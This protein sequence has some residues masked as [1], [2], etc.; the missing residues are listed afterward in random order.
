MQVRDYEPLIEPASD[1]RNGEETAALAC[2]R[3]IAAIISTSFGFAWLGWGST[4]LHGLP[5]EIWTAYLLATCAL[6]ALA[7]RALRRGRKMLEAQEGA[8]LR[9]WQRRRKAYRILTLGEIGGCLIVVALANLFHRTDWIAVG[10][11]FVVGLHFLPLSRILGV[12]TY[13]WVGASI[14]TFDAVAIV[15]R[16][17]LNPTAFA[18]I[19]TGLILWISAIYALVRSSGAGAHAPG[20]VSSR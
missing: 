16:E 4:A 20:G 11:S 6:L 9:F 19:A 2:G 17:S 8:W 18:G 3:G 12:A 10:I 15:T 14:V 1:A 5:W 7:I 13:Y